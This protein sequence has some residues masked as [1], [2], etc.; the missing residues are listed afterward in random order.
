M[1]KT[2]II[3][4]LKIFNENISINNNKLE[5]SRNFLYEYRENNQYNFLSIITLLDKP[6]LFNKKYI[7]VDFKTCQNYEEIKINEFTKVKSINE[8][9]QKCSDNEECKY[10]GVDEDYKKIDT[11]IFHKKENDFK[12]F[13][14]K[15]KCQECNINNCKDVLGN[16]KKLLCDDKIQ[17]QFN[18]NKD[19]KFIKNQ[20]LK[21]G[22]MFQS[23]IEFKKKFMRCKKNLSE[24]NKYLYDTKYKCKSK[25]ND[26]IN[27]TKNMHWDNKGIYKIN[28]VVSWIQR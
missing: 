28:L 15:D 16:K 20:Y 26:M 3:S 13:L 22:R 11:D 1:I 10:F 27:R 6:E 9:A 19:Y 25:Y 12:C 21:C 8:C 2:E 5:L 23:C 18:K 24:V 17:D 7:N 4:K 14:L